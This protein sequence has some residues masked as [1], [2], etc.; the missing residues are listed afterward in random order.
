M[1]MGKLCSWGPAGLRKG[2]WERGEESGTLKSEQCLYDDLVSGPKEIYLRKT[3]VLFL[4]WRRQ[5]IGTRFWS[6]QQWKGL[7]EP[8]FIE[9]L[10]SL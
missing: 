6:W 10:G 7:G 9:H 8:A 2:P 3:Y 1:K 4:S 5:R